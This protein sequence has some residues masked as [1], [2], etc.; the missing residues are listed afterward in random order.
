[1]ISEVV[2]ASIRGISFSLNSFFAALASAASPV[3]IG[4]LADRFPITVDGETKGHLANAFLCVTPLVLIG[5]IIVLRGRRH[6][7]GDK[8]LVR[9]EAASV[10]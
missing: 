6:V 4:F 3:T 10:T 8:A 7:D 9:A 1:M 2:P 5:A